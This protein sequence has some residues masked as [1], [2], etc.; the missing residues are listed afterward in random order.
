MQLIPL[1]RKCEVGKRNFP[2]LQTCHFPTVNTVIS[3]N[4]RGFPQLVTQKSAVVT[5]ELE[6]TIWPGTPQKSRL[7][8]KFS[9]KLP[10]DI[11]LVYSL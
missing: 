4:V 2:R 5:S 11:P 3:L 6:V 1:T 9:I 10:D 8:L 7:A